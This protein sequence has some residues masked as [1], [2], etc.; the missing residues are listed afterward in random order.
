[1]A[2]VSVPRQ[3][4]SPA[5]LLVEEFREESWRATHADADAFLTLISTRLI[6]QERDALIA[7]GL[8]VFGYRLTAA[9]RL[10]EVRLLERALLLDAAPERRR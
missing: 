3:R 1:M 9:V 7:V 10:V 2:A 6:R 5:W 8:T 4:T